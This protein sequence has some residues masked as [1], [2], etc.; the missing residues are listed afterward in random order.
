MSESEVKY[1]K[2]DKW[3]YG[4]VKE[5]ELIAF[6]NRFENEKYYLSLLKTE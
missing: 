4:E 6:D 5:I 3:V 2:V 1:K